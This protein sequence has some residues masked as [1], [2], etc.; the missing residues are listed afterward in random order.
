M[1]LTLQRAPRALES[2]CPCCSRGELPLLWI[3]LCPGFAHRNRPDGVQHGQPPTPAPT[4]PTHF[5]TQ[6][7]TFHLR[8]WEWAQPLQDKAMLCTVLPE[9]AARR[10]GLRV[11]RVRVR[12]GAKY[13][14]GKPSLGW[15]S[16]KY[17]RICLQPSSKADCVQG[18]HESALRAQA[19]DVLAGRAFPTRQP[20]GRVNVS[21]GLGTCWEGAQATDRVQAQTQP[22]PQTQGKG[23]RGQ[24]TTTRARGQALSPA[25]RGCAP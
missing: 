16:H 25:L 4:L 11:L 15:K 9:S 22:F 21:L 17:P 23:P 12:V 10:W 24:F 19:T 5:P 1:A 3:R 14:P 20:L 13:E 6:P 2:C 8:V 7:F 18:N